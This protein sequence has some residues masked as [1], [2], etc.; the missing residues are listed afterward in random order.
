MSDQNSASSTF[1]W[2]Y[3]CGSKR[4]AKLPG[5]VSNLYKQVGPRNNIDLLCISHFDSDHVIGIKELLAKFKVDRLALPY[6]PFDRRLEIVFE[7]ENEESASADAIIFALDPIGYLENRNLSSRVEQVL[8]IRGGG[9]Q[10]PEP[11]NQNERASLDKPREGLVLDLE[12][13]SRD[14]TGDY[15]ST[16]SSVG[17]ASSKLKIFADSVIGKITNADWEF[18]FFNKPLHKAKTPKSK[19]PLSDVQSEV[20]STIATYLEDQ[21]TSNLIKNLKSIYEKHFGKSSKKRNDISLCLLSRSVKSSPPRDCRW[22]Y[23]LASHWLYVSYSFI[24][25]QK[26]VNKS[27]LLL[28]GDISIDRKTAT[29]MCQHFGPTRCNDLY[30]MQIPHHGSKGS[31]SVGLA[32]IFQNAFSVLCVPNFDTAGHHPHPKVIADIESKNPIRADYSNGVI[33]SFHK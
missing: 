21:N 19:K 33:F 2:V 28:T 18:V 22:F 24:P 26:G 27:A 11:S 7:L 31:W 13:E 17:G 30:V 14:D 9:G 3:D 23:R 29:A 1:L 6:V 15:W 32:N 20:Q 25:V 10:A 5:F 12:G 8:L 16:S 4:T